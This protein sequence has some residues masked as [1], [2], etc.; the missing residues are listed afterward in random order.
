MFTE[1][2]GKVAD[3]IWFQASTC[4]GSSVSFLNADQPDLFQIVNKLGV[5]VVFH[6][7]LD[8][9]TG[10]DAMKTLDPY[11]KEEKKLDVLAVEGAIA[12]GPDGTGMAC[13]VGGKP[14][15]ETVMELAKVAHYTVAVGTCAAFGGVVAA[16]PNPTDAT[17][18][19]FHKDKEGGFLGAA[20]RSRGGLPVINVPGCPAHPDWASKSMAALLL[21]M[22]VELDQY[23]RP[24]AFYDSLSHWG[25]IHNEFYEFKVE[26]VMFGC[27]GCLFLELG[28]KGPLTHADCNT[29]LWNRQSSKTRVGSPCVGCTEPNFPDEHSGHYFTTPTTLGVPARLPIGVSRGSYIAYSGV[30]KSAAPSR[31]KEAAKPPHKKEV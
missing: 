4:A 9:K 7:T 16:D 28:C 19:Q 22:P 18:L 6:P 10:Q 11:I 25:C 24:K 5:N 31:L 20:Y 17:G 15:K 2:V 30:A 12:R 29:R 13:I 21:G 3:L 14:A 8:P 26:R 1:A 27:A 23:N